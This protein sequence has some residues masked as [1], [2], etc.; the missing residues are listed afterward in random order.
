[1]K[2]LIVED[3]RLTREDMIDVVRRASDDAEIFSAADYPSAMKIAEIE[4]IDVAFVDI[5]LGGRSGIELVR[6]LQDLRHEIN[7]IITTAYEQYAIEAFKLYVSGYLLKPVMEQDIELA[8]RNLRNPVSSDEDEKKLKIVAFGNFDALYNDKPLRFRRSKSKELLAYL[9][10]LRGA[11]AS[12][13]QISAIIWDDYELK[14]QHYLRNIFAEL[15]RTLKECGLEDVLVHVHN[16]YAIDPTKVDC[17]YYD[18]L[19]G[20]LNGKIINTSAF[21]NQYSWA[22]E[23]VYNL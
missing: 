20:K 13:A 18:Y 9:V 14:S 8:L 16:S 12:S 2:F 4:T 7:I 6:S 19:S 17:D 10:C 21:M 15:R 1:M 11:S 22:E 5:D 23:F 3:E